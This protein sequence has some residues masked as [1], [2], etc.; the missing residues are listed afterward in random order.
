MGRRWSEVKTRFPSPLSIHHCRALDEE[1]CTHIMLRVLPKLERNLVSGRDTR[2]VSEARTSSGCLLDPTD[3]PAKVG[4]DLQELICGATHKSANYVEDW[5]VLRY[6]VGQ[7]YRPHF[8][9]FQPGTACFRAR[10]AE[11]GQR[12]HTAILCLQPADEGGELVFPGVRTNIVPKRG[13]LY[14]WNN[15]NEDG[16]S[17]MDALH[18]ST[19]VVAGV[20]WSM[21]TWVRQFPFERDENYHA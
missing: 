17:L 21:V 4:A 7:E 15:V 8:D 9:W 18:G 13:H 14:L 16:I 12:T 3:L 10:M 2:V 20:K 6:E 11:G 19:A 1:V 5:Q